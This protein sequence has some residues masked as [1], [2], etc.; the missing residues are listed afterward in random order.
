MVLRHRPKK[1]FCSVDIPRD[2]IGQGS[3]AFVL[4]LDSPD[5]ICRR[6]H[7]NGLSMTD[8]DTRLLVSTD[9]VVIRSELIA[10]GDS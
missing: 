4:K 7:S 5:L 1:E 9:H 8:L 6:S 2:K 3:L 10:E